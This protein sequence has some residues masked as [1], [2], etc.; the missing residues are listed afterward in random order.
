VD[1]AANFVKC[2][3]ISKEA[4]DNLN[5]RLSSMGVGIY[6]IPIPKKVYNVNGIYKSYC[7]LKNLCDKEEYNIVHCHSPFGGVIA[8]IAAKDIRKFKGTKVIYTAHGFHFYKGAPFRNWIFYLV[9]KV[10]SIFNDMIITINTEDYEF[11]KKHF[12]SAKVEYIPGVGVDTASYKLDNFDKT[13]KRDKLGI[14]ECAFMLTSV[15]ELNKNK[16]HEVIIKT[17]AMLKNDNIHYVIAGKGNK[18]QD[19]RALAKRCGIERQI[20]I[21]GYREDI[22]EIYNCSD[23]CVFPSIREGLGIA[24]IEGMA[25]GLPLICSENRGSKSYACNGENAL[26]CKYNDVEGFKNA[27]M[28]LYNNPELREKWGEKNI[29]LS[30][31]YDKSKVNAIMMRIYCS[32]V[33]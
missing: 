18:Y 3:P 9:E 31:K 21:L 4:V 11:A 24:A 33:D 30:N 23:V 1:V 5:Q 29:K 2:G 26:V 16:N 7:M 12:A 8:R 14:P 13:L 25:A 15:G 19:L 22:A 20:H 28:T 6:Q 17:L 32:L 10:V 27:I